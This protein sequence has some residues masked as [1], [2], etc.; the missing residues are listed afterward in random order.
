[1]AEALERLLGFLPG[2]LTAGREAGLLERLMGVG[3]VPF[4]TIVS[5]RRK[6][7][8]G[9]ISV[10]LDEVVEPEGM[11]YSIGEVEVMAEG[12]DEILR[13]QQR[14]EEFIRDN[15]IQV[16]PLNPPPS[17]TGP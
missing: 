16:T 10:D 3:C 13:A 14:I 1:M 5:R 17:R 6:Y 7:A 15:G 12:E 2:A 4:C 9:G 8:G 11:D